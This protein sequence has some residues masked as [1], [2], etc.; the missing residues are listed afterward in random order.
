LTFF[1]ALWSRS[2]RVPQAVQVHSRM[3]RGLGPSLMPQA[4]QVWEVGSNRPILT[5]LRPCR[6]DAEGELN[7]LLTY[8]RK[9]VKPDVGRLRAAHEALIADASRA[10]PAGC[11]G[12]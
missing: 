8:D 11:P 9:V 5:S 7:G 6:A 1:A 4:E 2:W 3:F 10:T 12:T